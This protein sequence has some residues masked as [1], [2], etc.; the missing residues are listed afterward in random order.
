MSGVDVP[1]EPRK[2][3]DREDTAARRSMED[4]KAENVAENKQAQP[5]QAGGICACCDILLCC[6]GFLTLSGLRT[7]IAQAMMF[8]P[9]NPPYYACEEK[10]NETDGQ[11]KTIQRIY[12]GQKS[13]DGVENKHRVSSFTETVKLYYV[14]TRYGERVCVTF[15]QCVGSSTTIF[16]SHANA[17]DMGAMREL[18]RDMVTILK[19]NVFAYDYT[20]YG[21]SSGKPAPRHIIA[22]AEAAF[23]SMM[24]SFPESCKTVIVYGQSLGST[25][26]SHL[27]TRRKDKIHGAVIHCGLMSSLRVLKR[28]ITETLFFDPFPN[29]DVI[30]ESSCF[31]LIVHGTDDEDIPIHHGMGIARNAPNPYPHHVY[32]GVKG[33]LAIK[34]AG[35]NNIENDERFQAKYFKGVKEF[36]RFVES[37]NPTVTQQSAIDISIGSNSSSSSSSSRDTGDN[38]GNKYEVKG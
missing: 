35:H 9:P 29:V 6:F 25:A 22:D 5:S 2:S 4:G 15:H 19:V 27:T 36:V 7:R 1:L 34:G 37:R 16:F 28:D 3:A 20:G 17:A 21:L 33:V 38:S 31:V 30:K 18:F 8:F 12:W 23:D 32:Q 13:Q 11:G 14:P 24:T 26:T 10:D